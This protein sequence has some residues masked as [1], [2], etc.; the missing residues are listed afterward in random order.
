MES[1]RLMILTE[2]L[3]IIVLNTVLFFVAAYFERLLPIKLLIKKIFPFIFVTTIFIILCF[4]VINYYYSQVLLQKTLVDNLN[5]SLLKLSSNLKIEKML[6]NCLE[7]LIDFYNGELGILLILDENLKNFVSTDIISQTCKKLNSNKNKKA[8]E[9]IYKILTPNKLTY[10]NEKKIKELIKEYEFDKYL[11]VIAI[12]IFDEK[13]TKAVCIIGVFGKGKKEISK[14]FEAS[15]SVIEVFLKHLNLELENSLLHEKLNIASITDAL[16]EVY[17]RRYFN[18]RLKEEFAK[19]RREGYPFSIMISDLDNFKRYVDTYGHPMGDIILKE[20]ASFLKSTIRE[21][22][23]ICRFGGD[24]FAYLL[25]FSTSLDAKVVAE[26]I[27]KNIQNFKFLKDKINEDIHLTLSIGIASFPEHGNS[28]EEILTK[29]D[30]ALFMAKSMG[31]NKIVIY[32]E[33]GG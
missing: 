28:D 31:K 2:V 4:L 24:E 18:I 1:K 13:K 22:D 5:N 14:I 15:K 8:N 21:T 7:I 23:I 33:K 16:T 10:E 11:G 29:A 9:Y 6:Q 32:E 27:K 30:I 26:R 3:I 17:N 12:P 20:V 25:P 19:A